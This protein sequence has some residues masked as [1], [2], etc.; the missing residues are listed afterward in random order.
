MESC[1]QS[2]ADKILKSNFK[3]KVHNPLSY[4][5]PSYLFHGKSYHSDP[6]ESAVNSLA[7]VKIYS[8][9]GALH[10]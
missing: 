2:F 8:D 10:N 1:I 7:N 9:L 4:T 6:G 3:K 5:C